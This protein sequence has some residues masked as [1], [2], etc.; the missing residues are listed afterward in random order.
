MIRRLITAAAAVAL[1]AAGAYSATA[2]D[3][4]SEGDDTIVEPCVP[5]DGSPAVDATYAVEH[6]YE[7]TV[8]D[9]PYVPAVPEQAATYETL[10]KWVKIMYGIPVDWQWATA[11]PGA[12]WEPYPNA[13]QQWSKTGAELTPYVPGVPAIDE[14]THVE[15]VWAETV[16]DGDGWTDTGETR[17]GRELTPAIPAVDPV[18][19]DDTPTPEPT[20]TPTT[21]P[22][23]TP[24][25]VETPVT[26]PAAPAA[27]AVV[28]QPTVTG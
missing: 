19:C 26:P 3:E 7:R 6:R 24:P 14:V 28:A 23:E 2:A 27:R 8:V 16:P 11:D 13:E 15:S 21:P 18:V 5:S 17:Q 4:P 20:E 12:K 9:Q 10:L 22:V 1:V 25:A